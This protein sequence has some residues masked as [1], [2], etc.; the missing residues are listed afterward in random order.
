LSVKVYKLESCRSVEETRGE[1]DVVN[2]RGGRGQVCVRCREVLAQCRQLGLQSFLPCVVLQ[3]GDK[4]QRRAASNPGLWSDSSS[5]GEESPDYIGQPEANLSGHPHIAV[6][7][8]RMPTSGQTGSRLPEFRIGTG[9]QMVELQIM[10]LLFL[11]SPALDF[12]RN[13]DLYSVF[14][15]VAEAWTKPHSHLSLNR[16]NFVFYSQ[17]CRL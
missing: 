6:L 2:C 1:S 10:E 14:C 9:S 13:C 4:A 16:P 7:L 8:K 3:E 12:R 5:D 15:V 11:L 17:L